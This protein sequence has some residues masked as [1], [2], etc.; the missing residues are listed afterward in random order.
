[1]NS[2]L[3]FARDKEKHFF[4]ELFVKSGGISSIV[5]LCSHD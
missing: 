4:Y 5:T 2:M 3:L 1:M